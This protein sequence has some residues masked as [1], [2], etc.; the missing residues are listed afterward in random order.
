MNRRRYEAYVAVR[1][2]VARQALTVEPADVLTELAE[3]LLLARDES[4]AC[5]AAAPVAD[6]LASLVARGALPRFAAHR[7][8][9]LLRGCGPR[10]AWPTSWDHA[11][12]AWPSTAVRGH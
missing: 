4:E 6:S 11:T 10:I 12:E 3:G 5:R 9:A 2:A 8:W 1:E 7:F